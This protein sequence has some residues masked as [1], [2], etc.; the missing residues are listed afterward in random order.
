LV[1]PP[2]RYMP[3]RGN[4]II[5]VLIRC[6]IACHHITAVAPMVTAA[7]SRM[8]AQPTLARHRRFLLTQ[9]EPRS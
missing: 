7:S 9:M 2:A 5:F 3:P 1:A 6:K 4:K 8:A